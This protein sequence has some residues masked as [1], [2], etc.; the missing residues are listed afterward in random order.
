[1]MLVTAAVDAAMKKD[2]AASFRQSFTAVCAVA[3]IQPTPTSFVVDVMMYSD[4]RSLRDWR[5]VLI[6]IW[7]MTVDAYNYTGI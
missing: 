6:T 4:R 3:E 1:M 7:T 2:R 5:L